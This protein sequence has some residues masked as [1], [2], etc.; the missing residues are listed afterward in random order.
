[1]ARKYPGFTLRHDPLKLRLVP[2]I[3][4]FLLA[5][6]PAKA[7]SGSSS[8]RSSGAAPQKLACPSLDFRKFF[9]AFA[10]EPSIQRRFTRFPLTY[11]KVE[12]LSPGDPF[13]RRKIRAFEAVPTFST[14]D[15]GSIFPSRKLRAR[16][17]FEIQMKDGTDEDFENTEAEKGDVGVNSSGVIVVLYEAD[18]GFHIYYR[19]RRRLDCWY[20]VEID[21]KST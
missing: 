3:M 1:M 18:T 19:F 4:C 5:G 12:M 2:I 9:D 11:G 16:E 13:E 10:Q 7:D 21:D 15:G 14:K 17:N 6:T 8:V 20:L